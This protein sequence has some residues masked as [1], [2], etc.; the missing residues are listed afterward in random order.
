MASIT[1]H[2]KDFFA[3][4]S[5]C[6]DSRATTRLIAILLALVDMDLKG[7]KTITIGWEETYGELLPS[8]RV[9]RKE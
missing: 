6:S 9:E 5:T 3:H 4:Y 2:L 1:S 7:I 8:L